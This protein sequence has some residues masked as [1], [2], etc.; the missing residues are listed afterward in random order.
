MNDN[1]PS[2]NANDSRP[3]TSNFFVSIEEKISNRRDAIQIQQISS[4][5][6]NLHLIAED[7]ILEAHPGHNNLFEAILLLVD[8]V[9]RNRRGYLG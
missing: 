1:L 2:E 3:F 9:H 5:P 6:I 8:Y 7:K 4:N